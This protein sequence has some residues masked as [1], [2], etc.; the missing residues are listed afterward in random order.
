MIQPQAA[1]KAWI[2]AN[3]ICVHNTQAQ[4]PLI[5]S[6][7]TAVLR[8]NGCLYSTDMV[9]AA[10]RKQQRSTR[11]D[12]ILYEDTRKYTARYHHHM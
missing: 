10:Y 6:R 3:I 7:S 4:M 5:I 2:R 11:V 9:D 12:F 8:R 1:L